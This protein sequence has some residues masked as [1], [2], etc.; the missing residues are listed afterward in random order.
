MAVDLRAENDV[1]KRQVGEVPDA[2]GRYGQFGG[3]YAPETLMPA[4]DELEAAYE[5]ARRD[6]KFQD[7][8]D[9][10]ARDYVGR[11]TPLYFARNLTDR[12][13]GAL[14]RIGITV[15]PS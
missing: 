3:K 11:P 14:A 15:P 5:E 13:G 12:G 1:G 7:I 4:L 6:P 9:R 2:R 10:L 8:L